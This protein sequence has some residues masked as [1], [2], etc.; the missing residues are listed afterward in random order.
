MGSRDFGLVLIPGL[1][2]IRS[3]DNPHE[4]DPLLSN[5]LDIVIAATFAD[6]S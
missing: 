2:D 1:V 6:R 3:S 5:R 4:P